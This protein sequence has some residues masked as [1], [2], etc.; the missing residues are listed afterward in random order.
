MLA[1]RILVLNSPARCKCISEIR[2]YAPR[3]PVADTA[4][5]LKGT[6]WQYVSYLARSDG[7]DVS[8]VPT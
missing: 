4:P 1:F 6:V 3:D 8:I 2:S 5:T 7:H